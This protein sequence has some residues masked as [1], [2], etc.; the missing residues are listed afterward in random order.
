MTEKRRSW[1]DLKKTGEALGFTVRTWEARSFSVF[2]PREPTTFR[3]VRSPRGLERL[4]KRVMCCGCQHYRRADDRAEPE[5]KPEQ[6]D[7]SSGE[8]EAGAWD[9]YRL[10]RFVWWLAGCAAGARP[11]CRKFEDEAPPKIPGGWWSLVALPCPKHEP[12]TE[13][14]EGGTL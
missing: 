13:I 9:E 14:A 6:Y 12:K 8:G 4:I 11:D 10:D 7:R 5:P 3:P 2:D 1:A